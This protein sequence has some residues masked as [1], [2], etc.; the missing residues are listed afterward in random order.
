LYVD[1]RVRFGHQFGGGF[2]VHVPND[3]HRFALFVLA[4]TAQIAA[5]F[6]ELEQIQRVL[7]IAKYSQRFSSLKVPQ[8]NETVLARL[9]RRNQRI[10][11]VQSDTRDTIGMAHITILLTGAQMVSDHDGMTTINEIFTIT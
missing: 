3:N 11:R 4:N 2:Q 7:V 5:T 8:A 9:A 1:V 10:V 6:G